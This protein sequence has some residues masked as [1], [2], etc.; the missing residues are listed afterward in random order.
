MHQVG[1]LQESTIA[2]LQDQTFQ[3]TGFYWTAQPCQ[4]KALQ[5]FEVSGTNKAPTQHRIPEGLKL[6]CKL[7]HQFASD[8]NPRYYYGSDIHFLHWHV[9]NATI[10]CRSQELLPFL[11]IYPFLPPF[12][13][14]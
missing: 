12:S 9:Q 4:I 5:S 2:H 6:I 14:N 7:Q 13:T 11:F 10:P 8:G 3:K 1:Y